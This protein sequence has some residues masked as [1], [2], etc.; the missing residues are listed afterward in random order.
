M[1]QWFSGEMEVRI[2]ELGITRVADDKSFFLFP[3]LIN[4]Q[5]FSTMFLTTVIERLNPLHFKLFFNYFFLA[6]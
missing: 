6:I 3:R 5:R 2:G 4:K 1:C